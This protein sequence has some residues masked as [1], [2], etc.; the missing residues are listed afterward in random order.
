VTCLD[1]LLFAYRFNPHADPAELFRSTRLTRFVESQVAAA[2]AAGGRMMTVGWAMRPETQMPYGLAS[3]EGYDAMELAPYRRLL[4]RAKVAEIHDTGMIPD[5]ARPLLDLIGLRYLVTPP[6][7]MV[8]GPEIAL[9][10]DGPDGRVFINHRARPRLSFVP[11]AAMARADPLETIV[12][13]AFHPDREILIEGDGSEGSRPEDSSSPSV[14]RI[15]VHRDKPGDLDLTLSGHHG[16]YL[17]FTEAHDEGWRAFVNGEPADVLR[18]NYCFMAV[19][20]PEGSSRV[21]LVY[22]PLSFRAGAVISVLSLP[23]CAL[24]AL[25]LRRS[26][27]NSGCPPDS[28]PRP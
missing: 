17:A 6:D 27:L 14:P 4:E 11:R 25:L 20:L 18:A 28:L 13:A 10:Y 5:D 2:P 26:R 7:V 9:G 22:A 3:I 24:V 1:M 21:R 19:A 15:D 8:A 12:S 16:G 23:A